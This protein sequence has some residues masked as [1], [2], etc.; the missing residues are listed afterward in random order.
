MRGVTGE[1]GV[2][3]FPPDALLLWLTSKPA[4]AALVNARRHFRVFLQRIGEL[5]LPLEHRGRPIPGLVAIHALG[6]VVGALRKPVGSPL[7]GT[8]G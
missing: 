6:G 5:L 2:G 8:R 1:D 3:F 7:S 4:A